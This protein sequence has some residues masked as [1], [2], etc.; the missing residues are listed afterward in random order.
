MNQHLP[1][2]A[3]NQE[4]RARGLIDSVASLSLED[5]VRAALSSGGA[6]FEADG[7]DS[8]GL[9]ELPT[10]FPIQVDRRTRVFLEYHAKALGT[11]IAA[12]SGTILNEVVEATLLGRQPPTRPRYRPLVTTRHRQRS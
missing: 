5:V 12:L 7:Q 1:V 9:S 10:R 11:S 8:A 4:T 2:C 6:Q 3:L